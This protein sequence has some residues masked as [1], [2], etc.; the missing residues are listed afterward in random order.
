MKITLVRHAET[1]QNILDLCQ[2]RQ[3][4]QLSD[5]VSYVKGC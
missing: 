5:N 4:N 3:N 2:G 1:E